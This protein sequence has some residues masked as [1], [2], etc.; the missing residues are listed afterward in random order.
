MT[1]SA[2]YVQSNKLVGTHS[3]EQACRDMVA[4]NWEASVRKCSATRQWYDILRVYAMDALMDHKGM[5]SV[6]TCNVI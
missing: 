5:R 4:E 3:T 1:M 2:S 6:R